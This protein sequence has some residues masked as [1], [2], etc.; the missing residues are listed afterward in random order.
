MMN[1][2]PT[3]SH[4]RHWVI[5]AT[6]LI[7]ALATRLPAEAQDASELYRQA[8]RA[9]DLVVWINGNG[10]G[11]AVVFAIEGSSI[12]AMTAKHVVWRSG[13]LKGL[14]AQFR[15]WPG[16]RLDA[17]PHRFHHDRDFATLE[18][19][20]S[21]LGLS[22]LE[23]RRALPLEIL[24]NPAS[25]Q[26]GVGTYPVGHS[27]SATWLSPERPAAFNSFDVSRAI[28]REKDVIRV[29]QICPEGHSGGALFD[30]EWRLIG[31]IFENDPSYCRAWRLDWALSALQQWKYSISLKP[32]PSRKNQ[33]S[34][35]DQIHVVILDFDNRSTASL[36]DVDRAARDVISSYVLDLPRVV[37]LTRDRLDSV[38]DE[39][40]RV[41]TR[42]S[43]EDMA[44]IG[45]L[46]Q[47]D[48]IVTGSILRYDV[49]RRS[50][51]G[52]GANATVDVYR[53]DIS[54]SIL[55]VKTGRVSFSRVYDVQDR[56]TSYPGK[57]KD[58]S[59]PVDR[60]AELLRTLL[61]GAVGDLREG[62]TQLAL[63]L[64]VAGQQ[65]AVQITST[66]AGADIVVGSVFMGTTPT[67]LS[68]DVGLQEVEI[69]R[70]G[71]HQWL[72]KVKVEPGLQIH[73]NL[74]PIKP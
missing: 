48:A 42:R 2:E 50:F 34:R 4:I 44:R 56:R 72:R 1:P 10:E 73:V 14:K 25:L 6:L 61:D 13:P 38:K 35:Q 22:E 7:V 39:M 26:P 28:D 27:S 15:A 32:A 12:Y 58:Y 49:E 63:G 69:D 36:P 21:P 9:K 31:I 62:L 74:E 19:D 45:S 18:I 41:G 68:M 17:V 43:E 30:D 3:R 37:L 60:S 71:Y 47:A 67:T 46:L 52:H 70:P 33:I 8:E 57:S 55:D 65:V 59:K 16:R 5:L 23:I 54:L 11:A 64:P 53:M 66:P 51:S 29:E 20:M 24:G 40:L